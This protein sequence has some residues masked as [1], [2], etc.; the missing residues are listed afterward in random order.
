M[1]PCQNHLPIHALEMPVHAHAPRTY[2]YA[3]TSA[4]TDPAGIVKRNKTKQN[5]TNPKCK[6]AAIKLVSGNND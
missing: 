5:E 1:Q 3:L 4:H 2:T 6:H